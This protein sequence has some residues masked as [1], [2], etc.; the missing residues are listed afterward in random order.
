MNECRFYQGGCNIHGLSV[1]P[2]LCSVAADALHREVRALRNLRQ[3]LEDQLQ[4]Q[5]EMKDALQA[6]LAQA[7]AQLAE[8]REHLALLR[9]QAAERNTVPRSRF[10]VLQSLVGTLDAQVERYN[11]LLYAVETKHEGETRHQT[12]L[13]YIRERE[14][15]SDLGPAQ[16]TRAE[17]KA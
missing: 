4:H 16:A 3:G 2:A 10:D 1:P 11:E 15:P 6:L 17:E 8:T 14:H 9:V 7:E 5:C 12:A 13:R